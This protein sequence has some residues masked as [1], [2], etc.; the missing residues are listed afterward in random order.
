M[1]V[2]TQTHTV[3]NLK[4]ANKPPKDLKIN[5]PVIDLYKSVLAIIA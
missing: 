4:L 1:E 5:I 2:N 3:T